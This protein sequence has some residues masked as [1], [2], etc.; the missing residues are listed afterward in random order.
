MR[1]YHARLSALEKAL[2]WHKQ[3]RQRLRPIVF[4]FLCGTVEWPE[5]RDRLAGILAENGG[6]VLAFDKRP[7]RDEGQEWREAAVRDLAEAEAV[8]GDYRGPVDVQKPKPDATEWGQV[9][10]QRGIVVNF[11]VPG[12]Q[13]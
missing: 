3:Q 4:A 2:G 9:R 12:V 8:L 7:R 5:E 10:R 6:G 1:S 11:V 13:E